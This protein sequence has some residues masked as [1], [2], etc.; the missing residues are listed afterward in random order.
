MNAA[1]GTNTNE[2]LKKGFELHRTGDLARIDG[3]G[4]ITVTGRLKDVIVRGGIKINPLDVE[5][6]MEAH[7]AVV[8]A[9]VVPVPD[10]VLGERACLF[11]VLAPEQTLTLEDVTDYLAGAK[12]AKMFWPE[13]LVVVDSMPMTPTR[14]VIKGRLELPAE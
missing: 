6:L 14:K 3:D 9:A 10:E 13:R 8:Q 12:V 4:N 1:N 11:V 2:E 5:E 7:A